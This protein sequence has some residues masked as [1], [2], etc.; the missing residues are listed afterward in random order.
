[1]ILMILGFAAC[2]PV[3]PASQKE[4]FGEEVSNEKGI[5]FENERVKEG[6]Q[7]ARHFNAAVL[8]FEAGK[9][10]EAS[11]HLRKGANALLT[12]GQFLKGVTHERIDY[13]VRSLEVLANDI[14][15]GT[16][17]S[18]SNVEK[19]ISN[20]KLSVA[21]EYIVDL[22][23]VIVQIP[24]PDSYFPHYKA[25]ILSISEAIPYLDGHAKSA[26]ENLI[27]ESQELL[28]KL[29][30]ESDVSD[31]QMRNEKAKM[32]IFLKMHHLPNKR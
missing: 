21:Q 24:L 15:K 18:I 13:V 7:S 5:V 31:D 16:E 12:E 29:D 8:A 6:N 22:G 25:A 4:A 10:E 23:E 32:D 2:D 28:N 26:A 20:A 3:K 14:S 11:E 17:K 27:A 30:T 1:M 9:M 19:V